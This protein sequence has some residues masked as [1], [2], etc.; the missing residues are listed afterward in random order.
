MIIE[1]MTVPEIFVLQAWEKAGG[2]CECRRV[3]HGHTYARCTHRLVFENRGSGTSG[4]WA[5]RYVT[6]PGKGKPLAC[7]ILCLECYNLARADEFQ[8]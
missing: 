4:G 2:Q 7:E 1:E 6:A 8:K 5:P 3:S